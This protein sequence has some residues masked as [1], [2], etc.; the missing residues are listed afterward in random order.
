[1]E[2]I[3]KVLN[4]NNEIIKTYKVERNA[5]LMAY[6]DAQISNAKLCMYEHTIMAQKSDFCNWH[7]LRPEVK[8]YVDEHIS[9]ALVGGA[10]TDLLLELEPKDLD[11]LYLYN[12]QNGWQDVPREDFEQAP[13]Y[14]CYEGITDVL[15]RFYGFL[16][17]PY[18]YTNGPIP[19]SY[20]QCYKA[21]NHKIDF[22]FSYSKESKGEI[23]IFN[24][25][26]N[27]FDQDI[28][29]GIYNGKEFIIHEDMYNA[30]QNRK[31]SINKRL[32]SVTEKELFRLTKAKDKYE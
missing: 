24:Y 12:A 11:I 18:C 21:K 31:V 32:K 29:L 27:L 13:T 22:L 6:I 28:K 16:S 15:K 17:K 9:V 4:D 2:K 5:N 3:V 1:M 10:V 30:L 26:L 8:E 25:V 7:V 20:V 23:G 19:N 14:I